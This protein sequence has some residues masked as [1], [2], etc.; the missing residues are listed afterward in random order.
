MYTRNWSLLINKWERRRDCALI[1][2]KTSMRGR[3]ERELEPHFPSEG[4]PGVTIRAWRHFRGMTVT[5]LAIQA[6]FGKN[7]RG[8]ISKIEHG[9]IRRLGEEQLAAIAQA[10]GLAQIDLQQS[11]MPKTQ[12]S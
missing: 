5:D 12:E 4:E 1:K 6:G 11:R 3:R 9:L 10:L 7:G 2:E 8:Y